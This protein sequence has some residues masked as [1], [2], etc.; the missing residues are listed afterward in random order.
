MPTT[1]KLNSVSLLERGGVR[2]LGGIAH[3]AG[4]PGHIGESMVEGATKTLQTAGVT[5]CGCDVAIEFKRERNENT[6][7]AGSG[8]VLWAELEGG[9]LIGGSAVGRKG[10]DA[11]KVGAEAAEELIKA[12]GQDG[13]VDEVGSADMPVAFEGADV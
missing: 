2:K 5:S 13:C 9:G 12:L 7:G 1:G 6:V 8:I 10:V 4:L 3:F 11:F